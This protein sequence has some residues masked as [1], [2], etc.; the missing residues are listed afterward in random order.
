MI[1]RFKHGAKAVLHPDSNLY[2]GLAWTYGWLWNKPT[3]QRAARMRAFK[4]SR[5]DESELWMASACPSS[6][7]TA[8]IER[9]HP[10]S[11]LDVGCGTGKTLEFIVSRGIESVGL[12][13]SEAALAVS[14][15]KP[16]IRC[17]NLNEALDLGRKFDVVWSYEVAEHIHPCYTRVFLDTLIRHGDRIVM[18]AAQPGQGGAGHF[19]EQ[20][21]SYWIEKM[22]RRGFRHDQ[23]FSA[24]LHTMPEDH[25]PNI[26][27]FVRRA[28]T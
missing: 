10:R 8:I 12:E 28:L 19:N 9:W 2:N 21:L 18:S 17:T 1:K 23:E 16:L 5:F 25:S 4:D 24:H 13:G 27:V 22:D 14:P 7:L 11:F 6:L 20:P 26:M 15:I 3:V